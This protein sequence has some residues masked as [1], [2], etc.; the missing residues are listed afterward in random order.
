MTPS[1]QAASLGEVWERMPGAHEMATELVVV[2]TEGREFRYWLGAH[3]PSLTA[4]DVARIHRLW[5][6][7]TKEVGGSLHHSD[8][9]SAALSSFEEE[10]GGSHA[11]AL[12]R[13]RRARR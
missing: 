10:F 6:Q 1:D 11:V 5:L 8:V 2:S 12:A 13:L 9:V 7:A 3:A 4:D